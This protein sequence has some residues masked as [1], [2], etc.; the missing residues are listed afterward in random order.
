MKPHPKNL[1]DW[2]LA[3]AERRFST[4]HHGDFQ[5]WQNALE[6]LPSVYA[7]CEV[8]IGDTVTV[9]L[10][11]NTATAGL[12][13]TLQLLHPW[14]KGPFQIDST[15]IDTEWRSDWKWHRLSTLS[16]G[17]RILDIGSGNGYFGW[18][19][20]AAGADEVIGVDPTLLFCMQ[21]AAINHFIQ[22]DQNWVLPLGIEEIPLTTSFDMVF[23]MGVL[24][25]RRA[26]DQH[27]DKLFKLCAPQ[28]TTVV[29]SLVSP[30]SDNLVPEGRY[31]RM[32]NVW[33]VPSVDQIQQWM[34]NAG[35]QDVHLLDVSPT[36]IQEQ[37]TTQ[38]MRFESLAQAL[39]PVNSRLTIEGYPA[40]IRAVVVG[41]RP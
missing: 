22:S 30:D 41:Y 10:P 7:P 21:H 3:L 4:D 35:F 9:T 15:F 29:E 31:A 8:N 23:S 25:H 17:G 36:N 18:R 16:F 32:R 26:P 14:R 28:G 39:D 5:K 24:Y 12:A 33:C 38:W 6:A 1:P 27:I 34:S 20:L 19:M 11:E 37:R 13:D 2:P 40:P